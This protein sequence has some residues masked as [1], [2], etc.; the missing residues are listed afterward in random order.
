MTIY[1]EQD[2]DKIIVKFNYSSKLVQ[3]IRTIPGR[4]YEPDRKYWT[5]PLSARNNLLELFKNEK[6]I[7]DFPFSVTKTFQKTSEKIDTLFI[8]N[9]KA[10][11]SDLITNIITE[12]KLKGYQNTTRKSYL[13]HIYRY[14]TYIS[15]LIPYELVEKDPLIIKSN[16][17][18]L[19]NEL[20]HEN[21]KTYIITLLDDD[22]SHSYVNQ[23]IS[24]IN[25]FYKETINQDKKLQLDIKRPKKEN[26]LPKV[27]STQE[28]VKLFQAVDNLKY[29]T[30]FMLTYSGGLRVGE[31]VKLKLS[32]IDKDRKLICIRTGKGLKDRYTLLSA[33]ALNTLEK[34]MKIQ[35]TSQW[36]FPGQSKNSHLTVRSVQKEFSK[37]R[38]KAGITKEVSIH[39][40][41]HS[42]AT[43]LLEA[44]TDIRY[45]QELLGHKSTKTTQ[46]YTHVTKKELTKINSPLDNLFD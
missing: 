44:G 20:T 22:C 11:E 18:G 17:K 46:V 4:K 25:F 45:I 42:F 24:A 31:V 28:I 30:I 19:I 14:L 38:K 32:D 43:H 21:L 37:T 5:V 2:K 27:L 29:K 40:L 23:A 16:S 33:T 12:L 26:K 35:H 39:S 1:L 8:D 9:K 7:I 36:L 3:L 34:Y 10:M 15:Q 41:R 6:I 13:G